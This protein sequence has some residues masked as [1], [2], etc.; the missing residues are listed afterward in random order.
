MI[1]NDLHGQ[2]SCLSSIDQRVY[3]ECR[4]KIFLTEK[5]C[6]RDRKGTK[7]IKKFPQR[8]KPR[9]FQWKKMYPYKQINRK[10]LDPHVEYERNLSNK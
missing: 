2:I 3:T 6:T 7:I 9:D 1:Q 4:S 5:D 10:G 8:Y